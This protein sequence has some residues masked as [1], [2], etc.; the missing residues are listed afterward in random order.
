MSF[1]PACAEVFRYDDVEIDAV[2]D[3]VVCRYRLDGWEFEEHVRFP[4]GGGG[5]HRRNL[6]GGG[7]Q[8]AQRG[9]GSVPDASGSL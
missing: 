5:A 2:A 1:D 6:G 7:E 8:R 9:R 4:G 3:R